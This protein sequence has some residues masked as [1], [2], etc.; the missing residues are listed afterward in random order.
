MRE[1][2]PR[3][4]FYLSLSLSLSISSFL[5]LFLAFSSSVCLYHVGAEKPHGIHN[6]D[7]LSIKER[8]IL[9]IVFT[10]WGYVG[11]GY[12][13]RRAIRVKYV[14][15]SD[16]Y[17]YRACARV[18]MNVGMI[19]PLTRR[20]DADGPLRVDERSFYRKHALSGNWHRNWQKLFQFK[21]INPD[22]EEESRREYR[23]I[24]DSIKNITSNLK[25]FFQ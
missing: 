5:P 19:A 4:S 20:R 16:A 24:G 25:M 1:K 14:S 9:A 7:S 17:N 8:N 22:P 18:C 12:R 6:H 21:P 2:R 3:V 11:D 13:W 10:N 23:Q 15:W